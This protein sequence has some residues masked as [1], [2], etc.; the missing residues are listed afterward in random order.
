MNKIQTNKRGI[1]NFMLLSVVQKCLMKSSEKVIQCLKKLYL[2]ERILTQVLDTRF[3]FCYYPGCL[4]FSNC[5][6]FSVTKFF[7]ESM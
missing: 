5:L 2:K 6:I 3:R 4:M 7:G 1:N